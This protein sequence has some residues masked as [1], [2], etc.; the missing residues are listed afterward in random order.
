MSVR[1]AVIQRLHYRRPRAPKALRIRAWP[2]PILS[3]VGI[4]HDNAGSEHF[5]DG[6]NE[7]V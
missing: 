2:A 1:R 4:Y 3:D 6:S 5:A 7:I